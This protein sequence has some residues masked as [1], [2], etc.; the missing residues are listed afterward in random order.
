MTK[1]SMVTRMTVTA[2]RSTR[3]ARYVISQWNNLLSCEVFVI[4][5][6]LKMPPPR[7]RKQKLHWIYFEKLDETGKMARCR[8]CGGHY[9][10]SSTSHNLYNHLRRKHPNILPENADDSNDKVWEFF[11][12]ND[13]GEI[14]C[15]E[16]D[17]TFSDSE[18]IMLK[19]HLMHEHPEEFDKLIAFSIRDDEEETFL[20]QGRY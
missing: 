16:C 5:R 9:S 4:K 1:H 14:V 17:N 3:G 2:D 15:K 10:Y 6:F 12:K 19:T 20:L 7:K 11:S 13:E 8:I 18:I